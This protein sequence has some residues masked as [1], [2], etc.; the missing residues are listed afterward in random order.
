MIPIYPETQNNMENMRNKWYKIVGNMP[1]R[2]ANKLIIR[3]FD[4]LTFGLSYLLYLACLL[5]SFYRY[6]L[7]Y[8]VNIKCNKNEFFFRMQRLVI[9][10]LPILCYAGMVWNVCGSLLIFILKALHDDT[11]N[12]SV[13]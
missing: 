13:I 2:L 4:L 7:W 12:M 3:E 10:L 8:L 5:F 6:D 9:I 11:Q 1:K